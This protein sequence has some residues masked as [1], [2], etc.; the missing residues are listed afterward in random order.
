MRLYIVLGIALVWGSC[1]IRKNRE[2]LDHVEDYA[3]A[4]LDQ[5]RDTYGTEQSPL[6]ASSLIRET[7]SLPEGGSLASLLSLQR[8]SWGEHIGWDFN[9]ETTIDKDQ[10]YNHEFCRPWVFWKRCFELAPK[11]CIDFA[12]G[13]WYHQI[14]DHETGEFSRHAQYDQHGTGTAQQGLSRVRW[15]I[16]DLIICCCGRR[17]TWDW[18]SI[19][20]M[21]PQSCLGTWAGDWKRWHW[22]SMRF[23]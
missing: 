22:Q 16:L 3:N 6:I 15:I 11:N 12:S 17:V 20:G 14:H 23:I 5:G 8:E 19:C 13:L 1:Q 4:L 18:P 21:Q 7:M 2:Y 10:R 9:A